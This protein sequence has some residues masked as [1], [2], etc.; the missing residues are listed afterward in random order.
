MRFQLLFFSIFLIFSCDKEESD[1]WTEVHVKATDYNTGEPLSDIYIGI[2]EWN[3][4]LLFDSKGKSI[5]EGFTDANGEY[6]FEWKAKR[7]D[8]F[9]YEYLA[10]ANPSKYKQVIFQ[11]IDYLI[12]GNIHNY[13]IKLVETGFLT[14]NLV[15]TN[16][17]SVNDELHFRYFFPKPGFTEY[18]YGQTIYVLNAYW[19]EEDSPWDGCVNLIGGGG[20]QQLPAGTYTIEW[21]V[22]RDSGYTEGS[23][24]FF[25][26]NGDSLTYLL[27]Y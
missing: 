14:F 23:D 22:T 1:L 9:S 2:I 18:E 16:C 7:G 5:S 12:K 25:V 21:N 6:H 13:E 4:K 27:E 24:T 11:Q 17:E 20:Y 3:E 10:Q 19:P 15:N 26:G 8:G